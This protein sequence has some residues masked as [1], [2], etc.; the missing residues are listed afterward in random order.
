MSW[1]TLRRSRSA[2]DLQSPR[3]LFSLPHTSG[4]LV[5]DLMFL[6]LGKPTSVDGGNSFYNVGQS[7]KRGNFLFPKIPFKRI[8]KGEI[9]KEKLDNLI[10][11]ILVQRKLKQSL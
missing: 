9:R 10:L 8:I 11:D 2:A 1:G 3:F 6:F 5:V 7:R 4:P